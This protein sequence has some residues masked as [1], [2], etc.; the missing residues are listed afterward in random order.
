MDSTIITLD[1]P[2]A[3]AQF[4][5]RILRTLRF[6]LL[7]AIAG[8]AIPAAEQ[9]SLPWQFWLAF[10]LFFVSNIA[11]HFERTEVFARLRLS[12]VLFL[13]DTLVMGYMMYTL[14]ERSNEFFVLFALTIL[15]SAISRSVGGAF[16]CTL[17]V[18]SLYALLTFHHRTGVDFLS[19]AFLTRISLLFVLAIFIGYMAHEA[20]HARTAARLSSDLYRVMFTRNPAYIFLCDRWGRILEANRAVEIGLGYT[21]AV[22][23]GRSISDVARLPSAWISDGGRT[24]ESDPI[25]IVDLTL[26]RRNGAEVFAR[27]TL[28]RIA[29]SAGPF[30]LVQAHE[31][32]QELVAMR[33]AV[34]RSEKMAAVGQLVAGV[35]HELNNAL[36]SVIGFS[37]MLSRRIDEAEPNRQVHLIVRE[38]KRAAHVVQNLLVFSRRHKVERTTF[39]LND[40]VR[41]VLELKGYDLRSH[42][43]DV[44]PVLDPSLPNVLGDPHQVD[45]VVLN[46]LN[47]AQQALE[48]IPAGGRIRVRTSLADGRVVLAVS[49]N[50][51]GIAKD[52]GVRLFEPF[53]TTKAQGTGLG[54]S[55][56]RLIVRE[57]GGDITWESEPGKGA[58]FRVHLPAASGET[59]AIGREPDAKRTAGL[60]SLRVFVVDDEPAI[61]ASIADILSAAG[62]V[63]DTS[64]GGPEAVDTVI[65]GKHDVVLCDVTMPGLDGR[66]IYERVRAMRPGAE[67][68]VI[69]LSGDLASPRVNAFLEQSGRLLLQ[70]PFDADDLYA[71]I[72]QQVGRS[73]PPA[74]ARPSP[75]GRPVE[76]A[77][78]GGAP[79]QC[80][81]P[82][83]N[84][85][86][87]T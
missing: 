57:M 82:S 71:V 72:R 43:V 58:T 41:G 85:I 51:P 22:L 45:Q 74:A 1:A 48:G 56:A 40:A 36:T 21:A 31:E 32:S 81:P 14:G 42:C 18:G 7:L 75:C 34:F 70:K 9:A 8:S 60:R 87:R 13:F 38:A 5:K 25:E 86:S 65:S 73:L 4:R 79:P 44:D 49:D 33:E 12:A 20:D 29:S 16:V 66:K 55:V 46:L 63:V 62:A 3:I 77:P 30:L 35:A 68:R 69:F 64:L 78:A 47:N 84:G 50:G 11:Y 19:A 2:D 37:Q 80:S 53:A 39:S 23:R 26:R 54:L 10:S 15:M 59:E 61:L 6:L 28:A 83:G 17:A 67:T 27:A 52:V 24:A 76:A